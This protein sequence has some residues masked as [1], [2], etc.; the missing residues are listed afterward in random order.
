[1]KSKTSVTLPCLVLITALLGMSVSATLPAD[2]SR[3]PEGIGPGST[4]AEVKAVLGNP[5][6]TLELG[7]RKIVHFRLAK[8]IF[9]DGRI[10]EATFITEAERDREVGDRKAQHQQALARKEEIRTATLAKATELRDKQVLNPDFLKTDPEHRLRYWQKLQNWCPELDLTPQIQETA[11]DLKEFRRLELAT[12]AKALEL[13]VAR[14]EKQATI[15]EKKL[16]SAEKKVKAAEERLERA[17]R[18]ITQFP[19]LNPVVYP[20]STGIYIGPNGRFPIVYDPISGTWRHY[21]P[22]ASAQVII[23]R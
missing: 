19:V 9:E 17:K 20:R 5:E 8:I 21:Y 18:A 2:G 16:E 22:R 1:M 13:K 14:L 15:T 3:Y 12:Q 7:P 10:V 11:K 6:S 4:E 23:Q